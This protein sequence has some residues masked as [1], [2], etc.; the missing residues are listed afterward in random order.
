MDIN[1]PES[2]VFGT[3]LNT[4]KK[5]FLML[6]EGTKYMSRILIF[7]YKIHFFSNSVLVTRLKS[8]KM[9]FSSLFCRFLFG[10]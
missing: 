4:Q 5:K 2:R 9:G 10:Y 3:P 1:I 6:R 7:F 8:E